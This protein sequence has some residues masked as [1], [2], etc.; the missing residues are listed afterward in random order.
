MLGDKPLSDNYLTS[1]TWPEASTGL[2]PMLRLP[3]HRWAPENE[4]DWGF[5]RKSVQDDHECGTR[6]SDLAA[7]PTGPAT[8]PARKRDRRG[9]SLAGP[10]HVRVT[11]DNCLFLMSDTQARWPGTA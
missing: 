1:M 11:R 9:R 5:P 6:N 7:L 3:P 10:E 8:Q 4:D 2:A